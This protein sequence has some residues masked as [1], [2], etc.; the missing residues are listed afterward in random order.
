M[1]KLIGILETY[2]Q[3][4]AESIPQILVRSL[5]RCAMN[6]GK[7]RSIGDVSKAGKLL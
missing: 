6:E 4:V 7:R 3:L 2:N 1:D 5:R